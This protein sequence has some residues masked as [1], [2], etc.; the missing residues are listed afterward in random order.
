MGTSGILPYGNSDVNNKASNELVIN[1]VKHNENGINE[2]ESW[3]AGRMCLL[4]LG[5]PPGIPV[6]E[7]WVLTRHGAVCIFDG[8]FALWFRNPKIFQYL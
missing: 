2:T 7:G 4:P 1:P 8:V 3:H 5:Q 6:N